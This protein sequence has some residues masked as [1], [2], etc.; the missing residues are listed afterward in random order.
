M[1]PSPALGPGGHETYNFGRPFLGHHYSNIIILSEPC[2]SLE[3][4]EEFLE[5][6]SNLQFLLSDPV[7]QVT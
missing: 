1:W 5:N 3:N 4:D 2:P 6:T 7:T